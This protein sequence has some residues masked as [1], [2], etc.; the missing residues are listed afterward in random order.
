MNNRELYD[1]E[2]SMLLERY[3]K[4]NLIEHFR[5]VIIDLKLVDYLE[6]IQNL[7]CNYIKHL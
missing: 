4:T 7:W 1:T 6:K 5:V 3:R 2:V